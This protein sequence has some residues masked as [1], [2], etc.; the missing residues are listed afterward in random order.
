MTRRI[1]LF[2]YNEPMMN[3]L[4]FMIASIGDAHDVAAAVLLYVKPK[5]AFKARGAHVGR[6][7][8]PYFAPRHF[9][10][11]KELNRA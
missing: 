9:I 4:S 3:L 2:L 7:F 6:G 5:Q 1:I 11:H 10:F 8:L